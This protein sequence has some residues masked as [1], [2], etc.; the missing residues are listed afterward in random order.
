M[1]IFNELAELG[2]EQLLFCRN[3]EVGLRAIIGIHSTA[4]GPALGGVRLYPY[5]S[6]DDAGRDVLRLSRGMTYKAAV[7]GLDLGGGKAVMALSRPLRPE[8]RAGLL[9]RYVIPI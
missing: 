6:E 7:A 5:A 3:D 9:Q 8:E 1:S 4:L 2:H